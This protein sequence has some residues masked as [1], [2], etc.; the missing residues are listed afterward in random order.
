MTYYP[1][2]TGGTDCR[3]MRIELEVERVGIACFVLYRCIGMALT[4]STV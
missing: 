1:F 2:E 3:G 4:G